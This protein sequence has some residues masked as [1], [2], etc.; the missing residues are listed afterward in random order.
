MLVKDELASTIYEELICKPNCE[1]QIYGGSGDMF[2][3]RDICMHKGMI[4]GKSAGFTIVTNPSSKEIALER[5]AFLSDVFLELN[6]LVDDL[7]CPSQSVVEDYSRLL[8]EKIC[9]LF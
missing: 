3:Y 7:K 5:P 6:A 8:K 2:C 1:Y 4:K 9:K